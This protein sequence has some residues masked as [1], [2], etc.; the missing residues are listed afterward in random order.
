[1]TRFVFYFADANKNTDSESIREHLL[2]ITTT[3]REPR[4]VGKLAFAVSSSFCWLD[5]SRI[6]SA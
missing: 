2:R 4:K 6:S 3:K 5:G 1:M